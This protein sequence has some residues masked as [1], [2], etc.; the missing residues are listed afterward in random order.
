MSGNGG[1]QH[2]KSNY[3]RR[4]GEGRGMGE[5]ALTVFYNILF[6]NRRRQRKL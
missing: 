3:L 6:K 2:E 5:W 4:E 1:C